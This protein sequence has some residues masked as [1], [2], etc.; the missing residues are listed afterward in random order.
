MTRSIM[1]PIS[2]QTF[3][4]ISRFRFI[5]PTVRHPL[6]PSFPLTL[7]T[8]HQLQPLGPYKPRKIS[9]LQSVEDSPSSQSAEP[10][11]QSD[12]S[13]PRSS[14]GNTQIQF[15]PFPLNLFAPFT[16]SR[17]TQ[18]P[19]ILPFSTHISHCFTLFRCQINS[20]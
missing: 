13:Q 6:F 8:S 4:P 2:H 10:A 1:K 18:F 3:R 17:F 14:N 20:L 16:F 9:P 7:C 12:G 15:I 19:L 5:P 11:S